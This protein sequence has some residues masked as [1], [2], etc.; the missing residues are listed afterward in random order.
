[1]NIF[2]ANTFSIDIT[3]ICIRPKNAQRKKVDSIKSNEAINT[4]RHI[5]ETNKPGA[6]LDG[7]YR[8]ILDHSDTFCY[9]RKAY[10]LYFITSAIQIGPKKGVGAQNQRKCIFN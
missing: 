6:I 7:K 9:S 8:R 3:L 10:V 4:R 5:S 2:V 1:M